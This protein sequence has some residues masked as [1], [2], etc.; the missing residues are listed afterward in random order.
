MN[1]LIPGSV[2]RHFKGGYYTLLHKAKCS[3]TK[4]DMIVYMS[5]KDGQ[6][7]VRSRKEFFGYVDRPDYEYKG[8]RFTLQEV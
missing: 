3:S 8:P 2:Y 7:W 5:L 4:S 6:L 1:P